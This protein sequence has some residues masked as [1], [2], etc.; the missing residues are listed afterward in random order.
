MSPLLGFFG[1]R[2]GSGN[3]RQL[4]QYSNRIASRM[5]PTM[6]TVLSQAFQITPDHAQTA[7]QRL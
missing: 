6:M 4:G 2:H 1:A 5:L 3:A 7:L